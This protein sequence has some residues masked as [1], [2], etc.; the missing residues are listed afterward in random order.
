MKLK[1]LVLAW[2]CL[3]S[4]AFAQE[5]LIFAVDLI[6]HG[7]RTPYVDI[8][9]PAYQWSEGLGELTPLGM[10][11]VYQLGLS[12]RKIYIEDYHLLPATYQAST[13][14]VR[15]TDYDRTLMSAEAFLLG[16]YPQGSGPTLNN[17]RP[18][19]PN[20]FQPIPVH[21][22]ALDSDSLFAILSDA[23]RTTLIERYVYTQ[24]DWQAREA[25]LATKFPEWSAA[26]GIHITQ[27]YQL[28]VVADALDIRRANGVPLPANLSKEDVDAIIANG[29]WAFLKIYQNP[30][31][32]HAAAHNLL[33]QLDQYLSDASQGKSSLKYV[34]WSGHDSTIMALLG[35]LSASLTT[36][37]PYAADVNFMLFAEGDNHYTVK[38]TYNGV[39]VK[40]PACHHSN[41]CTLTE[42]VAIDHPVF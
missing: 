26:T 2:G 32:A 23:K 27:L 4:I 41:V 33:M 14:Y 11:Q 9:T 34:L 29:H 21:T 8:N 19:L 30:Q 12:K 22:V 36:P 3:V 5:K 24:K 31:I 1:M 25:A 7:A 15:S 13:M 39:P 6:R 40:I 18:A 17:G 38:V 10:Q 37:V 42:F 28:M 20:R 35:N 16:L